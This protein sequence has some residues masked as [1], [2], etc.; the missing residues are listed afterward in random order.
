MF[1]TFSDD[2]VVVSGSFL[3]LAHFLRILITFLAVATVL[4]LTLMLYAAES[5]KDVLAMR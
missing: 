1:C 4:V 3:R 5:F 2:T